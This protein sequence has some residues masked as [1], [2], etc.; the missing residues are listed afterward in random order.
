MTKY[1]FNF[2]D[3]IGVAAMVLVLL[4]TFSLLARI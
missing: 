1:Y 3:L 2:V 4:I